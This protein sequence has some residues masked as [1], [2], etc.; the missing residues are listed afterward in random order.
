[1]KKVILVVV[2]VV[3]MVGCAAWGAVES[4]KVNFSDPATYSADDH[5][6]IRRD[7]SSKMVFKDDGIS[8]EVLLETLVNAG[9]VSDHGGLTG[10]GD[11]DHTVYYNLTRLNT[12][13]GTS[14][15]GSGATYVESL[16]ISGAVGG[17]STIGAFVADSSIHYARPGGT[18]VVAKTNGQFSTIALAIA[19]LVVTY[20]A[21]GGTVY[22][23]PG[24]YDGGFSLAQNIRLVGEPGV[25]IQYGILG[26]YAVTVPGAGTGC[27]IRGINF[28]STNVTGQSQAILV[29]AGG[30]LIMRDC[31]FDWDSST[32]NDYAVYCAGD[33]I[34]YDCELVGW[35]YTLYAAQACQWNG[36]RIANSATGMAG[37]PVFIDDGGT[38]TFRD[39]IIDAN[40]SYFGIYGCTAARIYLYDATILDATTDLAGAWGTIFYTAGARYSTV[41]AD[42]TVTEITEGRATELRNYVEK[43]T[44]ATD[45][46]YRYRMDSVTKFS[47]DYEGNVYAAGD[48][49]GANIQGGSNVVTVAK[50]GGD[51]QT[52]QAAIDSI[53][54][55]ASTNTYVVLIYPG[56]YEE[57]VQIDKSWITLVGWD[58]EKTIIQYDNVI[59]GAIGYTDGVV[60]QRYA[61]CGLRNLTIKNIGE[62]DGTNTTPAVICSAGVAYIDNCYIGGNGGRD[63]LCI[64]GSNAN[65]T[66]WNTTVEQYR[67]G[68][69]ASHSIWVANS[70]ALKY[71]YSRVSVL[72]T[73]SGIQLNTSGAC[74]FYHVIFATPNYAIDSA[75]CGALKIYHCGIIGHNRMFSSA[76]YSSL[77]TNFSD[78]LNISI[79][80]DAVVYGNFQAGTAAG[81]GAIRWNETTKK[82]EFDDTGGA[83]GGSWLVNLYANLFTAT[84]GLK[85]DNIFDCLSLRTNGTERISSA[86][87]ITGTTI[88]ATTG[89]QH[90]GTNGI[91]KTFS[92]FDNDA[93]EHEIIIQGGIITQWTITA[94]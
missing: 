1:M 21:D 69:G 72:G 50:S 81:D 80:G 3:M 55:Q 67:A 58:R 71:Y 34:A 41:G 30:D 5:V 17:T 91:D 8:S 89:F 88:N 26:G 35:S 56:I 43:A 90:D 47:V 31:V 14:E 59:V 54:D 23:H 33:L 10:L 36:G 38:G 32:G 27:E 86:G 75:A 93:N 79:G 83:G 6:Y 20:G 40:G 77:D 51:Y 42:V 29:V 24:D 66:C 19:W 68:V 39:V 82:M 87:A 64:L 11:D 12:K 37:G 25:T 2:I 84:W 9:G 65:V 16:P 53:T 70:A 57:L 45:H 60:N 7:A 22:I 48:V 63:I 52:V 49:T 61:N 15:S 46:A 44:G 92:F 18:A 62:D 4:P 13:L 76:T 73:G 78:G 74:T 85:T 28:E 94:P